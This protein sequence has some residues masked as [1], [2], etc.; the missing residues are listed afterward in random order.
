MN[1]KIDHKY[2]QYYR[3]FNDVCNLIKGT[4]FRKTS[5][6]ELFEACFVYE[7]STLAK[8]ICLNDDDSMVPT[9]FLIYRKFIEDFVILN[10]FLNKGSKFE[11]EN[12]LLFKVAINDR[13]PDQKEREMVGSKFNIPRSLVNSRAKDDD[14]FLFQFLGSENKIT[15]MID[16]EVEANNYRAFGIFA[17][18]SIVPIY[19]SIENKIKELVSTFKGIYLEEAKSKSKRYYK[20]FKQIVTPNPEN[21]LEQSELMKLIY[22][23]VINP[24]EEM[25]EDLNKYYVA[26]ISILRISNCFIEQIGKLYVTKEYESILLCAKTYIELISVEL[27]L[28]KLQPVDRD[29]RTKIYLIVMM[30]DLNNDEDRNYFKEVYESVYKNLVKENF[31]E[32]CISAKNPLYLVFLKN[33]SFTIVAKEAIKNDE[34]ILHIYNLSCRMVHS[35]GQLIKYK[36]DMKSLSKKL[37][38]F[39]LTKTDELIFYA[40]TRYE[41]FNKDKEKKFKLLEEVKSGVNYINEFLKEEN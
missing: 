35:F 26:D 1:T 34:D 11:D 16:D 36:D 30:M 9:T 3:K 38:S 37:F 8:A 4:D 19:G 22:D 2:V 21:I 25:C 39:I 18:N 10:A 33:V 23:K 6:K 15:N 27:S 41:K 5:D 24:F 32:F 12:F 7:L 40:Q 20:Q 14:F 13:F 28:M 29:I 17:H 31:Y